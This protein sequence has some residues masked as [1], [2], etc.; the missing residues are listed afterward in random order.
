[1]KLTGKI[2]GDRYRVDEY[3]GSNGITQDYRVV[4]DEQRQADFIMR[5]LPEKLATDK[6]F[7][8]R[9]HR[10]AL[11]LAKLQHPNIMQFYGLEQDERLAFMLTEY[12]EGESLK[13]KIFDA[14]TP[15]SPQQI[16][17]ILHPT[18]NALQYLHKQGLVHGNVAPAN[19]IWT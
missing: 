16:Q 15:F 18:I 7:L 10:E 9:F 6:V 19:I 13:L 12:F 2:I 17:E 1:M 3:L 4:W 8:R 11:R 5:V 14:Q